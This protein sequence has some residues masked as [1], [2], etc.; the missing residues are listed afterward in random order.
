MHTYYSQNYA[1][2]IYLSLLIAQNDDF[3]AERT[4]QT[5]VARNYAVAL[6]SSFNR[7]QAIWYQ[8]LSRY[9]P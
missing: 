2:I 1:G 5:C 7:G 3:I 8:I 9:I 6:Y 4:Q